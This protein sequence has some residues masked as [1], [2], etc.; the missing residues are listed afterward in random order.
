MSAQF[1]RTTLLACCLIAGLAAAPAVVA[2]QPSPPSLYQR[3]G[4]YDVIAAVVDDFFG[5]FGNDAALAPFLG[6]INAPNAGRI[7]QHFVDFMCAEA[8]GPCVYNGL[9]MKAAHDG[10]NIGD[11]EFDAVI[12][13]FTAALENQRVPAAA[14]EELMSKL[15]AMKA[16]IVTPPG[17]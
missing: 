14:G 13:H 7:R 1:T 6:G 8:G 10:L 5:R 4:G 3:I 2:S 15:R 16:D 11:K 9:G 17:R 12:R